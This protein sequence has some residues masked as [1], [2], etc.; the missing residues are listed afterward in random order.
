MA[1]GYR[2]VPASDLLSLIHD[3]R[4]YCVA[5]NTNDL[6]VC[7]K[8]L[9]DGVVDYNNYA[10]KKISQKYKTLNFASVSFL[11]IGRQHTRNPKK[12]IETLEKGR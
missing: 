9:P 12:L 4:S 3:A 10:Y 5:F 1:I 11:L 8:K 6:S 2:H 7:R